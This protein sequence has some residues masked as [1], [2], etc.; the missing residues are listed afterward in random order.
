MI[1]TLQPAR[2]LWAGMGPS[3]TILGGEGP[4]LLNTGVTGLNGIVPRDRRKKT[5]SVDSCGDSAALQT[6][7]AGGALGCGT[8]GPG[9]AWGLGRL[10]GKSGRRKEAQLL[11][12]VWRRPAAGALRICGCRAADRFC[13]RDAALNLD[14]TKPLLGLSLPRGLV[15]SP[16]LYSQLRP[17]RTPSYS[18]TFSRWGPRSRLHQDPP[19]PAPPLFIHFYR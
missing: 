10:P 4:N 12:R 17:P 15:L 9:R 5:P 14:T 6:G 16:R 1:S 7:R 8:H 19:G 13:S 2:K 18:I 11:P 3:V